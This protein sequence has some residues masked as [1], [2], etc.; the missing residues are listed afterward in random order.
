MEL[1]NSITFIDVAELGSFTKAI[2]QLEEELDCLLFERIIIQLKTIIEY[3]SKNKFSDL[4]TDIT[5]Y[6]NA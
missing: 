3:I 5:L 4:S 1:R 2:E 6:K